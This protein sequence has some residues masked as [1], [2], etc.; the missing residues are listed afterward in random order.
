MSASTLDDS[1]IDAFLSRAPDWRR[2]GEAI[3]R[4]YQGTSA[5]QAITAMSR[6]AEAAEEANHHPELTW[7]YNRLHLELTSHDVGGLTQRDLRLASRIDEILA[8]VPRDDA[9]S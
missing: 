4:D 1:A 5:R 8:D 7:V 3:L 6:I 9:L 2:K